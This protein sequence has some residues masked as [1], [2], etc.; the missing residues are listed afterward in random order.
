MKYSF[1]IGLRIANF[2]SMKAQD[3]ARSL[4][5]YFDT[6]EIPVD[7]PALVE[8]LGIEFREEDLEGIDG[9]AFKGEKS[10]LII[11]NKNL[12]PERRRF[13]IAH[14]LAHIVM[15]HA[16]TYQICGREKGNARMES[17]AD[18]FAAELIMPESAMRAQW[19]R[20]RDNKEYRVEVLADRFGVSPTAMAIR[21][22]HLGLK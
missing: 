7:M 14:E 4:F 10:Q 17:D 21:I 15:P 1:D 5:K 3:Y 18:R 6:E 22:R 12:S 13:V 16:T 8:K 9:I 20:Y 19:E 11:V 2:I